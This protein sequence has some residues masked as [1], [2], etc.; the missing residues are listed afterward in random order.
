M[1]AENM[2]FS[3]TRGC[4]MGSI[5]KGL[6]ATRANTY[7]QKSKINPFDKRTKTKENNHMFFP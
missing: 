4:S 2:L 1:S 6:G 3:G 5:L 7:E